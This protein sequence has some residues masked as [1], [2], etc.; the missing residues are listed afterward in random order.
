M[1]YDAQADATK[2]QSM[3]VSQSRA[4]RADTSDQDPQLSRISQN[5]PYLRFDPAKS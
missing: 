4:F 2:E 5:S 3:S 1:T